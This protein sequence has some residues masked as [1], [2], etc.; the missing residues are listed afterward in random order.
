[1]DLAILLRNLTAH[2]DAATLGDV[3]EELQRMSMSSLAIDERLQILKRFVKLQHLTVDQLKRS[4]ASSPESLHMILLD[5]NML[6]VCKMSSAE[7]CDPVTTDLPVAPAD[8]ATPSLEARLV[9]SSVVVDPVVVVAP[10]VA[11]VAVVAPPVAPVAVVA[12]PVAPVAVAPPTASVV[13]VEAEVARMLQQLVSDAPVSWMSLPT[14][15]T[16]AMELAEQV[17]GLTGP[18]KRQ[19]VIDALLQLVRTVDKEAGISVADPVFEALLPSLVDHFVTV[20]KDG[21]SV[22]VPTTPA[23]CFAAF[24]CK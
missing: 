24:C 1:M 23:G 15:L 17:V 11:P 18:Q 21:I 12:P 19:L 8:S 16:H 4:A 2:N 10:P 20:S 22:N 6:E 9:A 5:I 3:I 7:C 13:V 14:T